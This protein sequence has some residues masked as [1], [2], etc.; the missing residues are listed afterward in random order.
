MIVPIPSEDWARAPDF[1]VQRRGA[2]VGP[3][4][5]RWCIG[6]VRAAPHAARRHRASWAV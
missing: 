6:R 1:Q 4:H 3:R 2:P 5:A